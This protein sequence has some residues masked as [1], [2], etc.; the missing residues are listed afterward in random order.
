MAHWVVL[1]AGPAGLAAAREALAAGEAVTV[2]DAVGPGGHALHNSLAPSKWGIALARARARLQ[3][4]GGIVPED[5][6]ARQR[7]A[8][9]EAIARV[10]GW[11]RNALAG[12]RLVLGQARWVP[13]AG[14]M[15]LAVAVE[16]GGEELLPDRIIVATGS[17]QRLVPGLPPDGK[18]VLLPR[19]WAQLDRLPR[20]LW[21][22]G[23]GATGLE[24]AEGF[25]RLGVSVTL[26]GSQPRLL[27]DWAPEVGERVERH[28]R[29]LGVAMRLGM[30]V[31]R[32][33]RDPRG[34][35]EVWGEAGPVAAVE[36]VLLATGRV[37][38]FSPAALQE[39]GLAADARGFLKVDGRGRTNRLGVWAA[40]DA[41]G[42]PL[43]AS[44]AAVEGRR[45]AL[46]ALGRDPGP[47]PPWVEAI[48]VEPEV[49]RVGWTPTTGAARPFR[50]RTASLPPAPM[51][52]A[53]WH[54]GE[55]WLALYTDPAD[56][57][58][59]GAEAVG[60]EA[61]ALISWIGL[62][63]TADLPWGVVQRGA[64]ATP[65]SLEWLWYLKDLE[66]GR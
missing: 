23:T 45:A 47:R 59:L 12:A 30:R 60:P 39:A 66:G 31:L 34:R 28:L 3:P 54:P 14:P 8:Q 21:V 43:L 50:R 27:P 11:H 37:G 64:F 56:D 53:A 4:Y 61:A 19:A 9:A 65:S 18:Q 40:G 49:A 1:G 26:V 62:A 5:F 38:A 57:R 29:A 15:G 58:V 13:G 17:Q 7:P 20:Q 32:L 44:K 42:Y 24:A 46:D 63:V 10:A 16:P 52:V 41:A 51:A 48:Y 2:V 33:A 25:G 35:V 22:I 55:G 6:W 36:A